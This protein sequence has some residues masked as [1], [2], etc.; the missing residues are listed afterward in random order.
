VNPVCRILLLCA[1]ALS[2]WAQGAANL[3]RFED[4]P[5]P[6]DFTGKPAPP[7]LI[8][9]QDRKFRTVIREGAAKGPNF[10]GHYT[11][12]SW[13]CG[14]GCV[15]MAIV[16]SRD[17][18]VFQPPFAALSVAT[19][20]VEVEPLTFK[21]DSRLLIVRGCPEEK[22]CA[23]YFYRWEAP[24]FKLI[25]RVGEAPA[26]DHAFCAPAHSTAASTSESSG[27]AYMA[28]CSPT[29][30]AGSAAIPAAIAWRAK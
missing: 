8:H 18:T 17:G 14:G 21:L 16:D 24:R 5:S 29:A 20:P 15:S 26:G 4:Y 11:I 7:K 25:R 6:K 1:V 28:S 27:I 22:N 19:M 2:A 9:P 12:V 23:T 13:G 3:P 10:A 30:R